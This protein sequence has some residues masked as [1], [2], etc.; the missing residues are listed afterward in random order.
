[1]N[2]PFGEIENTRLTINFSSADFSIASVLSAIREHL[3]MLREMGITFLGA[4]T[5][6]PPGPSPVF[7]PVSIKAIFEYTGGSGAEK[8]LL[9]AYEILWEGVINTFPGEALW[10][11]SKKA[12]AE[13]IRA[14]AELLRARIESASSEN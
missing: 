1:M 4:A 12:Y 13:Y 3:D 6:A 2:L 5:D 7:K 9:R 8:Y 10:A 14:Q 11:E